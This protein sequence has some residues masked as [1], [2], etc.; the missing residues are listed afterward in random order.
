[1]R[2][3]LLLFGESFR[4]GG[5][6]NRN[7]GSA[8]SYDGQMKAVQSQVDLI[9]HLRRKGIEM[10]VGISSYTTPYQEDILKLYPRV[11]FY[12]FH[13][14]LL[15]QNELIRLGLKQA[16]IDQDYDFVFYMRI[17]LL[18]KSPFL[19]IVE[20]WQTIRFISVCWK[21][22]DRYGNHPRVNDMMLYI[23]KKYFKYLSRIHLSH[24]TWKNLID[25]GLT[26]ED[27]D[28]MCD[29]YHDSDSA[30]DYNPYYSIVNRPEC[31]THHTNKFFDKYNF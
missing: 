22:W 26:Y 28:M 31:S 17:D 20:P 19:D 21:Y 23:P 3:L 11:V 16:N 27:L 29:T 2:G 8:E 5:Q 15:G 13:P 24:E 7:R 1:M 9:D 14:Y 30:I 10:D 12:L 18:I 4:L 6:G 25:I